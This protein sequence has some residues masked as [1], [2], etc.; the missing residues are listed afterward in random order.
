[1]ECTKQFPLNSNWKQKPTNLSAP[2]PPV[3]LSRG[4][5]WATPGGG[6]GH[7]ALIADP[8]ALLVDI[9]VRVHGGKGAGR[10]IGPIKL[11]AERG[12]KVIGGD[13]R[14][15]LVEGI[16]GDLR[17]GFK[18]HSILCV[19]CV[20][21]LLCIMSHLCHHARA[22]CSLLYHHCHLM[23]SPGH[24][25]CHLCHYIFNVAVFPKV[26]SKQSNNQTD[27]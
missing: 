21:S 24:H 10:E 27:G 8:P 9:L 18:E 26:E 20:T 1:M 19:N 6:G 14:R 7:E 17:R 16:G 23:T 15:G 12:E 4:G 5:H 25:H 13:W 11:M 3:T 22:S 2:P